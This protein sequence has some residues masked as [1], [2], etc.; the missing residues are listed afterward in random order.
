VEE[1]RAEMS[2][3]GEEVD[4]NHALIRGL[5]RGIAIYTNEVSERSERALRKTSIRRATTKLN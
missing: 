3:S 4:I 1:I 5:R 2:K